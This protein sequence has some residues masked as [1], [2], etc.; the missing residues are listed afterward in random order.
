MAPRKEIFWR[1]TG[2][3]RPVAKTHAKAA[4]VTMRDIAAQHPGSVYAS[5]VAAS[6]WLSKLN[7]SGR[8]KRLSRLQG[9]PLLR[10]FDREIK[11]LWRM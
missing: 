7:I 11:R 1:G 5:L 8:A 9:P 3:R 10:A 6:D 4:H 2:R